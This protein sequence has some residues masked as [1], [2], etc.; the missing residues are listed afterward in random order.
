MYT[1]MRMIVLNHNAIV[2][3]FIFAMK[4]KKSKNR[5]NGETIVV[6]WHGF[7]HIFL[8]KERTYT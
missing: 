5:V 3:Y 2:I 8:N 4:F 1:K 7:V 6:E